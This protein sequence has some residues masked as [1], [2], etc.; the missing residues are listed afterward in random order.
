LVFPRLR[1]LWLAAGIVVA[2]SRVVIGEHYPGDVLAGA[3]FGVMFTLGLARTAWF[4]E[5]LQA[6][7]PAS[8]RVGDSPPGSAAGANAAP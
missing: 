6:P 2:S 5:A 8:P 4:R 3:W 1:A 7:G